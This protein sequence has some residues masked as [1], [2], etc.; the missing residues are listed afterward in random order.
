[1]RKEE[2]KNQNKLFNK[3]YATA[4]GGVGDKEIMF[5]LTY[6]K[7]SMGNSF[8]S[9]INVEILHYGLGIKASSKDKIIGYFEI[10][11]GYYGFFSLQLTID[12]GVTVG[13]K[14]YFGNKM[15]VGI[16][17]LSLVSGIDKVEGNEV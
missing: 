15:I 10:G 11:G 4:I 6:R 1:M 14:F 17:G 13:G 16:S 3:N 7:A 12:A 9:Y 5:D 8:N 2:L